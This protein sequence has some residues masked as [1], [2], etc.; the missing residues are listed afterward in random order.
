M[1]FR[2]TKGDAGEA[3]AEAHLVSLGCA[4]LERNFNADGGEVDIICREGGVLLFV[5]V[6]TRGRKR[7][8]EPAEAVGPAKQRRII[9][10]AMAYLSE[11]EAWDEPCRFDVIAI[12]AD[13]EGKLCVSEH[14]KDAF[15]ASDMAEGGYQPF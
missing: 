1:S 10:A 12:A 3:I 4:I 9:A 8:G 14:I 7:Q 5:E 13:A 15:D 6:K 11:H 2:K